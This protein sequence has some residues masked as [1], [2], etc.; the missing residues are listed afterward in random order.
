[1]VEVSSCQRWGTDNTWRRVRRLGC[2]I[3][4]DISYALLFDGGGKVELVDEARDFG[5]GRNVPVKA[6]LA[7]VVR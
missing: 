7:T 6:T 4:G 1:M 2:F 5:G 3:Y